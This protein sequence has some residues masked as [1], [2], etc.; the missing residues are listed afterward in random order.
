MKHNTYNFADLACTLIHPAVG[1]LSIQGEGA[2]VIV[3]S[4]SNDTSTHETANDGTVMTS[5]I[6]SYSGT[7][8]ISVQQT[9]EAHKWLTKLNNY[10]IEAPTSEWAGISCMATSQDMGVTYEG[11]HMSIQKAPDE[12]FGQQG[13]M[14]SW[15]FLASELRR[16]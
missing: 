14:L 4:M 8:T 2:G 12:T 11:S 3:F 13:Q 15:V 1:Q 7:V 16:Y 6:N 10:L 9:S 5:K